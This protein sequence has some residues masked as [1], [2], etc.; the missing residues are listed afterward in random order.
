M[1]MLQYLILCVALKEQHIDDGQFVDVSMLLELFSHS[2]PD[3]RHWQRD[4][5]HGLD[6]GSL[7]SIT[8]SRR[9]FLETVNMDRHGRG[10]DPIVKTYGSHPFPVARNHS[11][12]RLVPA[13][14]CSMVSTVPEAIVVDSA[15]TG[16]S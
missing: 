5:I 9:L 11:S 14:G 4:V 15:H 6:L 13:A 12:L 8:I 2:C 16:A 10:N 3:D 7:R 1:P